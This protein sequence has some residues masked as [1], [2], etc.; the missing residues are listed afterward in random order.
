MRV[1][2]WPHARE[3]LGTIRLAHDEGEEA[4]VGAYEE[5]RRAVAQCDGVDFFYEPAS[6]VVAVGCDARQR[7]VGNNFIVASGKRTQRKSLWRR[8]EA[9]ADDHSRCVEARQRSKPIA[10]HF[11]HALERAERGG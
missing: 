4:A 2:V 5:A 9:G 11:S 6:A 10:R 3:P 7:D 1:R 8:V